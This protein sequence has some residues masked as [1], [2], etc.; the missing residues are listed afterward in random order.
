MDG[1]ACPR[2]A[3]KR[4]GRRAVDAISSSLASSSAGARPARCRTTP[5]SAR[6][7]GEHH[8]H[9]AAGARC[10]ARAGSSGL[11]PARAHTLARHRRRRRRR[12]RRPYRRQRSRHGAATDQVPRLLAGARTLALSRWSDHG[13]ERH[14]RRGRR[15]DRRGRPRVRC[16]Q[17]LLVLLPPPPPQQQQHCVHCPASVRQAR[18]HAA[19]SLIR[20]PLCRLRHRRECAP[21]GVAVGLRGAA[22]ARMVRQHAGRRRVGRAARGT[23]TLVYGTG[24]GHRAEQRHGHAGGV[25][26]RGA[27]PRARWIADR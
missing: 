25:G 24:V 12:P 11:V 16:G 22:A 10:V 26:S 1:P 3:R 19:C 27:G 15:V 21:D 2:Y 23:G 5:V 8:G 6:G 4:R 14:R 9:R 20:A 13:P 7:G 17:L 18:R